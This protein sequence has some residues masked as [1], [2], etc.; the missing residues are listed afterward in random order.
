MSQSIS[1]HTYQAVFP[2]S[3]AQLKSGTERVDKV[4]ARTLAS[5]RV[6]HRLNLRGNLTKDIT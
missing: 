2:L 3:A 6:T 5:M 1:L 4:Y